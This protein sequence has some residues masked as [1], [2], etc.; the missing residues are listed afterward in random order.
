MAGNHEPTSNALISSSF[1]AEAIVEHLRKGTSPSEEEAK[2]FDRPP[3]L[4]TLR[5]AMTPSDLGWSL[6]VVEEAA[7]PV[8]GLAASLAH[9]YIGEPEVRSCFENRWSTAD[10]YLRN[11]LMWQMLDNPDCYRLWR[12]RFFDFVLINWEVFTAFNL[13]FYGEPSKAVA[14][15]VSRIEDPTIPASKKWLYGCCVFSVD[16]GVV[17]RA[18][19][20]RSEHLAADAFSGMVV[21]AL[22]DRPCHGG[23]EQLPNLPTVTHQGV[24]LP[25]VFVADAVVARMREGHRPTD[26]AAGVLNRLPIISALRGCIT[27]DDLPWLC[28]LVGEESGETAALYLSLIDEYGATI[29]WVGDLLRARWATADAF[30]R[31]HLIWR[32]LDDPNLSPAWHDKLFHFVMEEWP[33]FRDVSR[34]FL[35]PPEGVPTQ[36]LKRLGDPSYIPSKKWACLCRLPDATD[37]PAAAK[38]LIRLGRDCGDGF[39]REVADRLL[40]RFYCGDS[41]DV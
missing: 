4:L 7:G 19:V 27:A 37:D 18:L 31:A 8:A 38:A 24:S 1:I 20:S 25:L 39:T 10:P 5:Q 34:Q 21:Q 30:F 16:S 11:R 2:H 40:K 14:H 33:T 6:R 13:A 22:L 41:G 9:D 15:L 3:L 35:G 26:A 29:A 12:E 17:G 23:D 32:L 28:Q 36:M